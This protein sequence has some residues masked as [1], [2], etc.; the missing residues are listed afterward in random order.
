MAQ[1]YSIQSL[2][3][4]KEYLNHP[5]LGQRLRTIANELLLLFEND[6][7]NVFGCPDD[8]K[9]KSCMTLFSLI[10]SSKESVF[11]KVLN[12]YF[13]GEVDTKTMDLIHQK[14]I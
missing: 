13:N 6:A 14:R 8:M 5:V 1:Y 9:L 7:K 10:D 11:R 2:D 4:A 3:E 12:K